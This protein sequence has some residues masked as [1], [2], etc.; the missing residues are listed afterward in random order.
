MLILCCDFSL[1]SF[2]GRSSRRSTL[3]V[4]VGGIGGGGES[5]RFQLPVP[6]GSGQRVPCHLMVPWT[7][8]G[9]QVLFGKR[10]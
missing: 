9:Q 8:L 6:F 10:M 5:L 7:D 4:Y 2:A 1:E 3:A